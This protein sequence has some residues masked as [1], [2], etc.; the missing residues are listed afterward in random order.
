VLSRRLP[1]PA[2][3]WLAPAAVAAVP[4][5]CSVAFRWRSYPI[6]CTCA[7]LQGLCCPLRQKQSDR[8]VSGL[9]GSL[10]DACT[11][12]HALPVM[13][14]LIT[15]DD[16]GPSPPLCI[17]WR[18]GKSGPGRFL[19]RHS[20]LPSALSASHSTVLNL[21]ITTSGPE[22]AS[23]RLLAPRAPPAPLQRCT[24]ACGP[25]PLR[26]ASPLPQ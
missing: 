2:A 3:L 18:S 7:G 16:G 19:Q 10:Y 22:A 9:Q 25:Y 21:S 15:R 12:A 26:P 13:N 5:D 1:L 11:A 17:S 23:P 14:R 4:P 8:G 24:P 20:G 6:L